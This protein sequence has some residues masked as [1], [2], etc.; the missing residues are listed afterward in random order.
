MKRVLYDKIE[1]Y[2]DQGQLHREDGPA[3]EHEQYKSWWVNGKRHRE[4]GPAIIWNDGAEFWWFDDQHYPSKEEW[5]QM[6]N[7]KAFI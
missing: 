5:E 3:I 1:Y 2:N 6:V 4:D 7:F